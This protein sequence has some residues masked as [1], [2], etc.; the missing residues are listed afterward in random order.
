M[1]KLKLGLIAILLFHLLSAQAQRNLGVGHDHVPSAASQADWGHVDFRTHNQD[2]FNGDRVPDLLTCNHI[3]VDGKHSI[4]VEI[5]DGKSNQTFF[6]WRWQKRHQVKGNGDKLLLTGCDIVY[7]RPGKPSVI[8]STAYASPSAG[9]RVRAPQFIMFNR[10]SDNRLVAKHIRIPGTNNFFTSASRSVR[11][12]QVPLRLRREGVKNGAFCFYAGYDS[13]L[14]FDRGYGN[15]TAFVK[16]EQGSGDSFVVKDLT[17]SSGLLWN[18]G[19][20]GT[21]LGRFNTIRMCSGGSKRYDGLHMMGGAF[22]DYN[23]DGLTD[24]ITVGQHASVRSHKMVLRS[25][26]PEKVYFETSRISDVQNGMT[27]FLKVMSLDENEKNADST[28]VYI[29]GETSNSCNSTPDHLRCFR[30]GQWQTVFP[31]GSRFSSAMG[32]VSVKANGKNKYV[33]KAPEI[34]NGS[35]VRFRYYRLTRAFKDKIEMHTRLIKRK[36]FVRAVGWACVPNRNARARITISSK[37]HWKEKGFKRYYQGLTN[38]GSEPMLR[39]RCMQPNSYPHRFDVRIDRKDL[40]TKR[41]RIHIRAD[42][43][44]NQHVSAPAR[45][46]A[47]SY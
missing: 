37:E 44:H 45:K 42:Y 1:L 35:R 9:V 7:L 5:K 20:Y 21:N 16:Y 22:L 17:A 12:T 32:T 31:Q 4:N 6:R 28:C 29:S 41:G 38:K 25:D 30:G 46:V 15:V 19:M 40:V 13:N 26:R 8:L 10:P 34:R 24:L 33:I 36:N 23:R 3:K 39:I 47:H 14:P 43:H 27:E 2:D 18:G 11:C